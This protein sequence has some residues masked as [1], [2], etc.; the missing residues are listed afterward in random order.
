MIVTAWNNGAHSRNGSG[1]GFRVHPTDRDALFSKDWTNLF[2]QIEGQGPE[3]EVAVKAEGFW[4]ET[5]APLVCPPVLG[6][7]LHLNGL[8]PWGRGNAPV[9][10]LEQVEGN[11]FRVEKAAKRHGA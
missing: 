9:F 11:H 2:L 1:Y 10:I 7:W 8:A 6:K 5:P 4:A 3:I